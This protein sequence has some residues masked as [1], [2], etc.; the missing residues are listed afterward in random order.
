[1]FGP[2]PSRRYRGRD[3]RQRLL[4][5]I[6]RSGLQGRG[7]AAF[8]AARKLTA[9]GHGRR[10]AVVV[11]NGCEGEPASHK[12][13]L[14]AELAPHL[15]IDG[16][17]LAAQ[18]TGAGAV[19]ICTEETSPAF[20][21]LSRAARERHNAMRLTVV[22]VPGH[23]VASEES[24]LASFLNDGESRP[25]GRRTRV[26]ESGIDGRPTYVGNV[27]T[28]AHLAQIARYGADWFRRA[29][30][31]SSPG[32]ALVTIGGAVRSP[33]VVELPYGT[34][35]G[36]ILDAAG[37]AVEPLQA[38][39]VGGYSGAWVASPS[40]LGVPFTHDDLARQQ[41]TVGVGALI[42]LPA[43]ACGIAETAHVL[44]YLAAESARQCGPCMFG[45]P[46]I[47][48]DFAA[49]T[50]A[51]TI[52]DRRATRALER[53]LEVIPGRGACAHPDGAVRL[54]ASALRVF[55]HDVE[56]HLAGRPCAYAGAP[57][58]LPLHARSRKRV[59]AP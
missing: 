45:L 42:A 53:R 46:A 6:S 12:D 5:E 37:G 34:R 18:A 50:V 8:P 39:L 10:R 20:V 47:A 25:T 11:A 58:R 49:M 19:F 1:M 38:L 51:S 24:A 27:E 44:R 31:P 41:T 28:L 55:A 3:G 26:F 36:D 22:G 14:L 2:L 29:G 40:A 23:F 4:D 13:K 43:A 17:L 52:T 33:G 15:V 56:L 9:V 30:T 48:A 16:A 59:T 21:A 54:A 57:P 35:L 7:G 32:T